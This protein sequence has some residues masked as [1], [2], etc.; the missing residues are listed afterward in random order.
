MKR[1][2]ASVITTLITVRLVDENACAGV[3][4]AL[5][6]VERRGNG[7]NGRAL[8]VGG[9]G[10]VPPGGTAAVVVVE[11]VVVAVVAVVVPCPAGVVAAVDVVVAAET[12]EV[13][14]DPGEARTRETSSRVT[15]QLL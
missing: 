10:V 5:A 8:P 14:V 3:T 9:F 11:P 1:S 12:P 4:S 6:I 15:P 7:A 13:P 2:A